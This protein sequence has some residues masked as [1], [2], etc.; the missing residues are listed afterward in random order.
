M[1]YFILSIKAEFFLLAYIFIFFPIFVLKISLTNC[2]SKRKENLL[3]I[4]L[5]LSFIFLFLYVIKIK[6]K[7][8]K[9]FLYLFIFIYNI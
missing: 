7:I 4:Y 1:K 6:L 3:I 5:K 8:K 2:F 9:L